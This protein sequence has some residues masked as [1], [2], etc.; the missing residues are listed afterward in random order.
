MFTE[1]HGLIVQDERNDGNIRST[2]N[3]KSRAPEAMQPS[4]RRARAFRKDQDAKTLLE[5]LAASIHDV[6]GIQRI[7]GAWEQARPVQQGPPPAAAIQD[8]LHRGRDV[9]QRGHEGGHVQQSRMV[10]HQH[11]RPLGQLTLDVARVEIQ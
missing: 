3:F 1:P 9:R 11:D 10:R 4:L 2:R 6:R 7:R 8:R 5:A